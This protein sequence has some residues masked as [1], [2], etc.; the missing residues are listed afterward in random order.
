V[1][2]SQVGQA[3][4]QG[5]VPPCEDF[6]PQLGRRFAEAVADIVP[7]ECRVLEDNRIVEPTLHD[8]LA[9]RSS[10]AAAFMRPLYD[11][12]QDFRRLVQENVLLG[13]RHESF[14]RQTLQPVHDNNWSELVQIARDVLEE[15]LSPSS[16]QEQLQQQRSVWSERVEQQ[17]EPLQEDYDEVQEKRKQNF[18][19]LICGQTAVDSFCRAVNNAKQSIA[20]ACNISLSEASSGGLDGS[21]PL[22]RLTYNGRLDQRRQAYSNTQSASTTAYQDALDT[23][24]QRLRQAVDAFEND[25][26]LPLQEFVEQAPKLASKSIAFEFPDDEIKFTVIESLKKRLI[27]LYDDVDLLDGIRINFRNN[28]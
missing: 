13:I 5:L 6:M 11:S 3:L 16:G 24:T 20:T 15:R 22:V 14:V 1:V 28:L 9:R 23:W 7:G 21:L 12:G 25:N 2:C 17:H 4:R 26:R 10:P 27:K 19:Q 8:A 18:P